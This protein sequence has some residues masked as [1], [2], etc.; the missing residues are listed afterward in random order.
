MANYLLLNFNH[1]SRRANNMA[2]TIEQGTSEVDAPR[3]DLTALG[4]AAL[5]IETPVAYVTD[6]PGQVASI[7]DAT[8]HARLIG[9]LARLD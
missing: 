8:H 9:R 6:F 4:A 1:N 3:S 5:A 2:T 7:S